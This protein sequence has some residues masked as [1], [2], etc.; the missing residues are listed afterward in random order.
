MPPGPD[1]LEFSDHIT[2]L[3]INVYVPMHLDIGHLHIQ[4]GYIFASHMYILI[5]TAVICTGTFV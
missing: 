2:K 4:T 3:L 5:T 1:A